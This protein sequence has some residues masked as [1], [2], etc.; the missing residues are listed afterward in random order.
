MA[1]VI[2][3]PFVS[4]SGNWTTIANG[5]FETGNVSSWTNDTFGKGSFSATSVMAFEGGF[6]AGASPFS[7]FTGPGFA[8][9]QAVSVT[10]GQDYVISAFTNTVNISG[11]NVRLD[12]LVNGVF[13][14]L[15]PFANNGVTEWQFLWFT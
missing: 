9:T 10:G 5:G 8:L 7:S 6:S 2:E 13:I 3:G 11:G 4:G 15:D 14:G 1:V 12:V